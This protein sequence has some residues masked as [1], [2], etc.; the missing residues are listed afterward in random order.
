[1]ESNRIMGRNSHILT[2]NSGSSSIK[3]SLYV[4]GETE[5]LVLS[6]EL[7]RIGVSQGFW[8]AFDDGGQQLTAQKLNLPDHEAA[9]KVLFAWLQ[10]H[11]AGKDL[12]AVGHR[13][14]HG[15]PAHVKTQVVAAPLLEG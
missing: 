9:L 10:D 5:R 13:L 15:G 3:F 14:G 11:E 4:L 8:E 6:G 1:M 2:I 7:G 12:D